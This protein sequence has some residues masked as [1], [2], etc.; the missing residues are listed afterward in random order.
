MAVND[1]AVSGYIYEVETGA[2]RPVVA[3]DA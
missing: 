3:A 1:I 2:L